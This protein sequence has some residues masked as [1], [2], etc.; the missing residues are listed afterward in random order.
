MSASESNGYK[1]QTNIN[2]D[3]GK[4]RVDISRADHFVDEVHEDG[5]VLSPLR[6]YQPRLTDGFICVVLLINFF[7]VNLSENLRK[8]ECIS[9]F[10][11]IFFSGR[12][13]CKDKSGL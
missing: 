3:D 7:T 2:N 11:V 9:L 8:K 13:V 4:S 5:H 1:W 10:N 6:P 12:V